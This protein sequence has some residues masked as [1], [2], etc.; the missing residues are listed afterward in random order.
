MIFEGEKGSITFYLNNKLIQSIP[1][2]K[3]NDLETLKSNANR[4]ILEGLKEGMNMKFMKKKFWLG[5]NKWRHSQFTDIDKDED[6][7]M[8]F[9]LAFFGLMKMKAIDEDGVGEGI[10]VMGPRKKKKKKKP[11][12]PPT[13]EPWKWTGKSSSCLA[14]IWPFSDTF[15]ER[16]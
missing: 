11:P 9:T 4:I 15:R 16:I 2:Y 5:V 7:I 12:P 10:L 3:D 13:P 1:M 6:D 8:L 14:A